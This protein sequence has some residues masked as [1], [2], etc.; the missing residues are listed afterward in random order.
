LRR[1]SLDV[2]ATPLSAH[3]LAPPLDAERLAGRTIVFTNGVFDILHAGH[4]ELLRRAKALGDVL[5]VGVNSDASTRRLKGASRPINGER[6]RAALVGALDAVDHV[7]LF[8]E[9]TPAEAIRALRPHVHVKGGD[10][11]AEALPEAEAIREVGGRIAI[12][13]LVADRSTSGVIDRI[14]TLV[15]DGVIE[16]A[17]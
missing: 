9:D 3:A 17:R 8:G 12:L 15:F 1:V 10:Y 2:Q 6:D 7:V 14:A 13:P 11:A 16:V 5:V 4:V